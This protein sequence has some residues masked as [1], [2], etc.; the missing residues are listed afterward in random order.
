M[1]QFTLSQLRDVADH[2]SL[3]TG[4][5]QTKP[6]YLRAK[7][8][9]QA[10]KSLV[11]CEALFTA[12]L[13]LEAKQWKKSR[14]GLQIL[15]SKFLVMQE[16]QKTIDELDE[17]IVFLKESVR[18]WFALDESERQ[19]ILQQFKRA[20]S[21]L[22]SKDDKSENHILHRY[23]RFAALKELVPYADNA[24]YL[25]EAIHHHENREKY[26]ENIEKIEDK[27]KKSKDRLKTVNRGFWVAI[28]FCVFV[29]TIPICFPFSISLW[30]RKNEVEHQ[31]A[32]HEEVLRRETKRLALSEEG[33]VAAQEIKHILDGVS[34]DQIRQTLLEV[35]DLR[36]EF[37]GPE[38]TS[39]STAIFLSYVDLHKTRLEELFGCA[40][41]SPLGIIKWFYDSVV[42]FK[43]IESSIARLQEERSDLLK[44]KNTEM[45][46]YSFDI[47]SNSLEKLQ[48]VVDVKMD[49]PFEEENKSFFGDICVH[50]PELL[51]QMREVLFYASRNHPIEVTYWDHLKVRIQGFSNMMS[52]CILDAEILG[53]KHAIRFEENIPILTEE[54]VPQEVM[55]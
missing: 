2:L 55:A 13:A 33:A 42:R 47:L 38:R 39:S 32:N 8:I 14:E 22:N 35:K 6:F 52:L 20:Q 11:L 9:R 17:K 16:K 41:S 3:L 30:K 28:F 4:V 25:C 40:P 21:F 29:V 34:L 53:A 24:N 23:N 26:E 50:L 7:Q 12:D 18:P 31:I 36:S 27:I 37:Q 19:R 51:A 1:P 48:E 43:N 10:D 54:S 5:F 49:F 45:K 15:K 44:Q 46:G